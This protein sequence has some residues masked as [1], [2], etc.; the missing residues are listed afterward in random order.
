MLYGACCAVMGKDDSGFSPTRDVA[1]IAEHD[2]GK[3]VKD[4]K[5][6]R[7]KGRIE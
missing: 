4:F 5:S 1:G 7:K 6:G 3:G 2:A